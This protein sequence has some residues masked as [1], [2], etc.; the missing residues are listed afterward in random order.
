MNPNLGSRALVSSPKASLAIGCIGVW[1]AAV[2]AAGSIGIWLAIG[3][4][5]IGLGIAVLALDWPGSREILRPSTRLILIGA[6]AGGLMAAATY[7]LYP[8]AARMTPVIANDT[9]ILYSAFRGPS[10]AVASLVLGP[11]ILGEELVWRSVVQTA[12]VRRL[13]PAAGVALAA[14]VYALAHTPLGAP[15]LVFVAFGCGLAWGALRVLSGRLA[16]ALVAHLVWDLLVLVWLPLD[17]R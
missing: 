4:A 17:S 5:S 13:G 10:P 15:V 16:P 6:A 9:A 2:V 7:V 14:G 3:G 12:L 11:V 8:V 1:V